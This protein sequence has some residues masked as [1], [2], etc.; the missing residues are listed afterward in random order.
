MKFFNNPKTNIS[1]RGRHEDVQLRKKINAANYTPV[2][3]VHSTEFLRLAIN[4]IELE[5]QIVQRMNL[6]EYNEG[7]RDAAIEAD[8]AAELAVGKKQYVNHIL[9]IKDII[10][11][12]NG[13]IERCELVKQQLKTDYDKYCAELRRLCD[14]KEP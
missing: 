3:Y 2:D 8:S 6:D 14:T 10:D 13:E 4:P 7:W 1:G 12:Q 5:R 11:L 9:V